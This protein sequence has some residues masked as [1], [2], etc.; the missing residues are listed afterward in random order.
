[1]SALETPIYRFAG[2]ELEP[3]ERRLSAAGQSIS[4]TPKVFDTLVLLVQRAGH[5]VSKDELMKAL[6]PRGYV[7]E[8][9]LTK[10]IWLIRRA[11]GTGEQDSLLIETVPKVGY[12]FVAAVNVSQAAQT[13]VVTPPA[14][15]ALSRQ[16]LPA[17]RRLRLWAA[18]TSVGIALTTAAVWRLAVMPVTTVTAGSGAR[19]HTVALIGFSNLSRNAKDAWLAPALSEVLGT[20]LNTAE[21]LR[22]IP[23]E[24]VHDASADLP[25]AAAGGYGPDTLERLRRRL[26]ADYIVSGSYLVTGSADNAPL[27]VDIALQDARDGSLLASVSNQADETQLMAL[28]SRAGA[29][30]RNKLGAPPAA[31]A[32]TPAL[33]AREQPPS[34]DVA[35]RM[36]FAIDALQHYDPARARDQLLE[37]VAEAPG[38]APAYTRLAQAWSALGYH[39]KALA[40]AEQAARYAA[41][42]PAEQRLLAEA[43]AAATH[44]DWAKAVASWQ[45]LVLL[46]PQNPEYRLK[47]IDAE[48]AAGM[49]S[50]AQATLADLQ[51]LPGAAEDPRVELAA[52][53]VASSRSDAKDA[54]SHSASA[55]RLARRRDANGLIADAQLALAGARM[56]LNQ[57]EEARADLAQGIGA[58]RT[59]GNPHGEAA[60]RAELAKVLGNLNRGREAHEEYQHAMALYQGIGDVGGVA[61]VYRD[62]CNLLWVAGDRDGAQTAARHSLEL[63]RQTDDLRLQTWTLRALA[64]IASDDSASDEVASEFQEVIALSE[65]DNDRGGHVWS[66][67]AYADTQRLRGELD[68]ALKFCRQALAEAAALSDPQFAVYSGFTCALVD[69]DR[70]AAGAARSKME[71]VIRE[72]GPGGGTTYRNNSLMNLAQLDMDEGRWS[73]ARDFLRRA[74][75]G[76]AAADEQTGEADASAMQALCDQ[77][78]GD[79]AG[80]E[81]AATRARTLR[82]SITSRQEV[83]VVDI[84][85]ARLGDAKAPRGATP[86]RL[87]ALAADADRRHFLGWALEARL[88]AWELESAQGDAAAEDLRR[89]IEV[90]A[91]RHGYGRILRR[92]QART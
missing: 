39:D 60:T 34:V 72:V 51:R 77:A 79:A 21:S 15:P 22:V 40:A 84:A 3:A 52:A 43:V 89:E 26:D 71:R 59:I 53:E 63:A 88:A 23:D 35:R 13:V 68:E 41:S 31:G 87:L 74:R 12:R 61:D 14:T 28:V 81:E 36:G 18:A 9:N 55:L 20:E 56:F 6:W 8:S 5:V 42:L 10:H 69:M 17:P 73:G 54:A 29:A 80:G 44:P 86:Q 70:G 58:Y 90:S 48:A 49:A 24:L 62:L 32:A 1:M 38:Y 7:D 11:L 78:L 27:R 85:L 37:A 83:Y 82:R 76:F 45:A 67:A 47:L 64:T 46:K 25:P 4:L 33:L 16:T 2:F 50:P 19:A 65:R 92:L 75:A 57:N 66:L 30:L 91:G